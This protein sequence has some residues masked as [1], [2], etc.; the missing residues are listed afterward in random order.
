MP[1]S[2]IQQGWNSSPSKFLAEIRCGRTK[3]VFERSVSQPVMETLP[4][5]IVESGKRMVM[6]LNFKAEVSFLSQPSRSGIL[7]IEISGICIPGAIHELLHRCSFN[8]CMKMRGHE[9]IGQQAGFGRE[10]CSGKT[11]ETH[12]QVFCAAEHNLFV[13]GQANVIYGSLIHGCKL[14]EHSSLA[15]PI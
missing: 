11:V 8:Q 7:C 10:S 4:Y 1:G 3:R 15:G 14:A 9:P 12:A 2:V 6:A 5:D 13:R